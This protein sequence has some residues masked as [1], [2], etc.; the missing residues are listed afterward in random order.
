MPRRF[1]PL[2]TAVIGLSIAA[3]AQVLVRMGT[4]APKDSRWYQI[5]IDMGQKWSQATAGKLKLRVYPGGAQGD[6][7]EMVQKM[8]IHELQAVALSGAGMSGIDASVSALQI[9]LMFDSY[10]ELDW[11]RD[12]IAPRLEKALLSHGYVVLN[13]ADAGWVHFFSKQPA[14]TPDDFRKLRLCVLQG[15][16]ATYELYK[17]NGFRPVSLAAT[18]IL[19]G[20]QTG[21]IDAFQAPALVAL[22]NQWFGGAPNMLDIKFATLV[23][24]TLI[25]KDV[26]DK[27]SP[28]EQKKILEISQESGLELRKEI[29]GLEDG[30]VGM[31]QTMGLNVVTAT[32]QA[33]A[34]W[35]ELIQTKL[36]PALRARGMPPDLFDEVKRLSAEYEAAHAAPKAKA[37]ARGS[38]RQ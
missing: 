7:P 35:K 24:A 21:L 29:R 34:A 32:P 27:F 17:N 19:T 12:R 2:L 22:T 33:R 38:R 3:Q 30:A 11:V 28:A 15:D 6:E 8:R 26:W 25:S 31:M 20:L 14:M 37:R 9:P 5:L 36:Y 18:D 13:W 4:L 1:F 23:G 16:S 10:D